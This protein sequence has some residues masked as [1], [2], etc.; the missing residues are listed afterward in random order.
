MSISIEDEEKLISITIKQMIDIKEEKK[1]INAV[2]KQTYIRRVLFEKCE[3][4]TPS[5]RM[6]LIED[7]NIYE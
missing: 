3:H 4:N 5:R 6:S 2:H 1:Y 7:L